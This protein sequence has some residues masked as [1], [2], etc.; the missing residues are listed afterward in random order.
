MPSKVSSLTVVP[1]AAEVI[2]SSNEQ[3]RSSPRRW[4][5]SCAVTA[6]ST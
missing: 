6:T 5:V 2:G 4:N 3:C 1:S